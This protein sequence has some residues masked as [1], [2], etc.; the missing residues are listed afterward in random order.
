MKALQLVGYVEGT[1]D[2]PSSAVGGATVP[3]SV[4]MKALRGPATTPHPLYAMRPTALWIKHPYAGTAPTSI[5]LTPAS[6]VVD[7]V[8]EEQTFSGSFT[9]PAFDTE[10]IVSLDYKEAVG[11]P[12][13]TQEYVSQVVLLSAAVV[14]QVT[15][16]MNSMLQMVMMIMMVV[17]V[18][19]GLK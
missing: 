3:I 2:L 4:V 9:M 6:E 11:D 10:V 7:S 19:K 13:S 8:G 16:D 5:A 14:P 18:M 17:V 15:F 1:L 12:W